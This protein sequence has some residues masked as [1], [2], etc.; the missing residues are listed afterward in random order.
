MNRQR[1]WHRVN[2]SN[3]C[4]VCHHTDWC[5]VTADGA[6]VRCQRVEQ[7]AFKTGT[8]KNGQTY[9]L[10]RQ[11]GAAPRAAAEPFA[12]G[13]GPAQ[14]AAASD[15]D[16]VYQALLAR[17]VLSQSHREQLHKRGLPD[18]EI[19]G[20]MYRSLPVQGRA[21]MARELGKRF[22]AETLLSV[23][24][25]VIKDKDGRKYITIAGA[26][27][28]LI[29]CRD[30]AGRI[31]ALKVRRDDAGDDLRYSYLSSAKYGGPSTGA[32]VHVPFGTQAPAERVRLTEGELK[33]DVATV[34][35]GM[36]T[37]SVP[38]V[39]SWKAGIPILRQLGTNIV[40]ISF[41]ADAAGKPAVARALSD[42]YAGLTSEGFG[43]AVERWDAEHKGIDDLLTAGKSAETLAG[44]AARAYIALTLATATAGEP[45]PP[46]DPLDRLSEVLSEG[47]AEGLYRD[48]ELLAALAK[49]AESNPAEFNCRRAQLRNHEIRLRELDAALSPLRQALRAERPP[50]TSAG[51]Y[52][53]SGG[54]IVRVRLTKDGPIE[55]AL[56]NFA[57]RIVSQTTVDDG[58]ERSI[59]LALEGELCDGTPLPR[60]EV[61][62]DKF[63]W[64]DWVVPS[65]GTRAVVNAGMATA[66]HLRCALQLLSGDVPMRTVYSHLGWRKIGERWCYLHAR[67]AIGA[68]GP[69]DDIEVSPP[70]ALARYVLPAPPDGEELRRAV[71][72][73]LAL[74]DFG[75]PRL[76]YTLL[77]SVYRAVLGGTD[78]S[79]HLAGPSGVFKSEDSALHQQHFGPEMDRSHLP[80]S[81]SSTSNSLEAIAFA[82][83]D[84]LLTVDDFAPHGTAADVARLNREAERLL[85]A[86]GNSAG[87][88]RM[89]ADGTLRPE[90]PPRGLILSTG[91]DVPRGQSLRAR[92]LTLEVSKGN[93]DA[94]KLTAFQRDAAAGRYAEA[95]AGFIRWL[96]PRYDDVR[97]RL[98]AERVQLRERAAGD[99]QHARTPGIL[100]DLA[101]GLR[102]L[103]DFAVECG[104]IDTAERAQ[105]WERGW[106]A[107]CEAGRTQAEHIESA[108]PTGH[109]L[110]LLG[111]ALASGRAHLAAPDGG[112]PETPSAWGWRREDG[113]N[114]PDW[115]PQGRRVGWIDGEQLYLEPEASYA[116]AQ[117]MA[118][119]QGESLT[120]S[121]PTLRRRLKERGLLASTDAKR[122]TLTV[123]RVLDG[124][125]RNVLHLRDSILCT[126]PD[127]PD[128]DHENA[129]KT[130]D[131]EC[132]VDGREAKNPTSDPTSDQTEHANDGRMSG[133]ECR[134]EG[135]ETQHPTSDPTSKTAGNAERNG[136]NVGFVGSET[137]IDPARAELF[138]A[139]WL[140]P[141]ETYESSR[142]PFDPPPA[143]EPGEEG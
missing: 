42:C 17:L 90:K 116:A 52:R 75:P 85:R 8:D 96:A 137:G 21:H 49:L 134:V 140:A 50:A 18:A 84:A 81:W 94:D 120:V 104:V 61:P 4:P 114:G 40:L 7:G 91:E 113:R 108:E 44:E 23:P 12:C 45:P 6:M 89:R 70:D 33:S 106:A 53:V 117:G 59:R 26:A 123:R 1:L 48:R 121:A 34:L 65:W 130:K 64:M 132:R 110:R 55:D 14:R 83:K 129:E 11:G 105:L 73:S 111:A 47:G 97:G 102:Y 131:S 86:Q 9:Y 122:E 95:M 58:A 76:A 135:R 80:A 56:C 39:A 38:G 5:A 51:E 35:S 138:S 74:L 20:R 66:D 25:F 2:K 60:V 19:D 118:G 27:G 71:K 57:A 107:L 13:N 43:V 3:P 100:A 62:A 16:A 32:P 10:H 127:K 115:R 78:F 99:G 54:R 133:S 37:I 109:F 88:Q 63:S 126:K 28:L 29:P 36:R 79:V 124:S 119:E 87:R 128:I 98:A 125:S 68:D 72:A 24:G 82:C 143:R 30:A 41:D 22:G 46:P 142:T 15:L 92:I 103:L 141:G 112:H 31:V 101:I 136:Q 93:F 69:V 67:G 139:P 77:A